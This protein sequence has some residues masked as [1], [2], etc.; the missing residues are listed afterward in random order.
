MRIDYV[1]KR[2]GV[3][4]LVVWLAA[5]VNFFAPRLTG[6]DPIRQKL[7]QQAMAGGYV[8]QG[9]EDMVKIYDREFGL[10]KP[11]W[12]QYLNYLRQISGLDL[13]Y[14]ITHYPKHVKELLGQGIVWSLALMGT[15]T[16]LAFLLGTFL[17]ALLTWP[18]APRFLQYLLPPLLTLSAMPYYILGLVLLYL[19]A[20]Q[21]GWFPIFGGYS[22][23]TVPSM[24]LGFWLDVL[25]H[26][27][28]PALS[29][30]L[31]AMG[32]WALG[33]RAMMVT[34]QGDDYMIFAEAK[35]LKEKTLFLRYAIRN[36]LLPQVTGLA[37]SLGY[38]VSGSVLV[39]VVFGYPGVGS[40]LYQAI[41]EFDYPTIQGIVFVIIVS[42]GLATLAVDILYPLLDPRITY[43][44][45]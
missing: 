43:R 21:T 15:T 44:R 2:I 23:G 18:K 4:F 39:E 16:I 19:F 1:L 14:S 45:A 40:I 38:I 13:G 41:S 28:L 6:T 5:T 26:T 8:Q 7:I 24:T 12:V 42:I 29:I 17:G 27:V 36:A 20:F 35:G 33:M 25:R 34:V 32:F 30:I 10:D 31:A 22:E 3:F 37:L 9:L 11:L